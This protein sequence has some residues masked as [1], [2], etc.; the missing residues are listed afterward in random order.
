MVIIEILKKYLGI[1]L[2]NMDG[3]VVGVLNDCNEIL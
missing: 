2:N 1:D 3:V